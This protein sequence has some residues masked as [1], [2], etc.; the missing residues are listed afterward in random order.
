[1]TLRRRAVLRRLLRMPRLIRR[2]C[3]GAPRSR[4]WCGK[5][6]RP[7]PVFERSGETPPGWTFQA[8]LGPR[9]R[10]GQP[11]LGGVSRG[12]SGAGLRQGRR[13]GRT[14]SS[15]SRRDEG[16]RRRRRRRPSG[17]RWQAS[18][19]RSDGPP[20][21]GLRRRR[22]G[23]ARSRS[24]SV[25][26]G[27]PVWSAGSMP[28]AW[29]SS[30]SASRSRSAERAARWARSAAIRDSM[31]A[32]GMAISPCRWRRR[33][34]RCRERW[35]RCT[36]ALCVLDSEPGSE[37]GDLGAGGSHSRFGGGDA[38]D[39]VGGTGHGCSLRQRLR[40]QRRTAG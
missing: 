32:A 20:R 33:R 34:P 37:V 17:P 14:G 13:R 39:V 28:A 40:C 16:P 12:R 10:W 5:A 26:A 15:R 9:P 21:R 23:P 11:Q 6:T 31:G 2:V 35:R 38:R 29:S 27:G 36:E 3:H 8:P 19:S 24:R 25:G 18:A 1:M 22:I 7:V 30:S 4:R